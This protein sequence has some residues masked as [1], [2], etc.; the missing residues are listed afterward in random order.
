MPALAKVIACPCIAGFQVVPPSLVISNS[1]LVALGS[2]VIAVASDISVI[3]R[4]RVTKDEVTM[5]VVVV[6]NLAS[7]GAAAPVQNILRAKLLLLQ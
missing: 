3:D 5:L 2:Y 4:V 1:M 7:D 6:G